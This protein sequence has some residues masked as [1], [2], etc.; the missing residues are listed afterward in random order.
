MLVARL[1]QR[2]G[3]LRYRQALPRRLFPASCRSEFITSGKKGHT[4]KLLTRIRPLLSP[5][6]RRG[7]KSSDEK[8]S[9]ARIILTS[10]Q[11][12][13]E[14]WK[15]LPGR[16]VDSGSPPHHH[17]YWG[18][19]RASPLL[20]HPAHHLP[21]PL[22]TKEKD[23]KHPPGRPSGPRAAVG[24]VRRRPIAC[25]WQPDTVGVP[26][27]CLCRVWHS[28][29][30]SPAHTFLSISPGLAVSFPSF[31]NPN[32]QYRRHSWI[33]AGE[34]IPSSIAVRHDQGRRRRLLDHRV[35]G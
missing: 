31:L 16:Q 22:R 9:S 19:S 4:I 14:P 20:A 2:K 33:I 18:S 23:Q 27:V 8:H 26:S 7:K 5:S 24:T 13:K 35:C 6:G 34:G 1:S 12:G 32:K 11:Q 17:D 25:S 10:S 29:S 28:P 15:R 21:S 30:A 3:P